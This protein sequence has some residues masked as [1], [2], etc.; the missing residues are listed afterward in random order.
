MNTQEKLK[1][2]FEEY[3]NGTLLKHEKPRHVAR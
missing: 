2:A 3:E 1:T